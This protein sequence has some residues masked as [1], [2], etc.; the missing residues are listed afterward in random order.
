MG[1]RDDNTTSTSGLVMNHFESKIYALR[2][3]YLVSGFNPIE[4]YQS[5]WGSSP[6]RD[7][8]KTYLK[9]PPR[10]LMFSI[11]SFKTAGFIGVPCLRSK[12]P[13]DWFSGLVVT[14]VV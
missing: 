12:V 11:G 8:N 1:P 7:E 6:G 4:K 10:Y 13:C 2:I 9:P 14:V 5:K 3:S